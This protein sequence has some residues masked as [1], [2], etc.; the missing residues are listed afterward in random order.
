MRWTVHGERTIYDSEWMRLALVD[1]ELPSGPR[2]EHHVL[3]MPAEAAGVVI[4]VA[5]RG[6]LL[7]WRHRFITDTWGWEIP[8]GRVDS[9]ESVA[10]AA[11]RETVE[12]SGWQ[13]GELT[14]M[15]R[16][17]PANGSSD[18]TF[19]LFATT[20]AT[21]VGEPAEL[22]EAERVEWLT[23]DTVR[24]EIA[25]GN[26]RD[27]LSLTALLYRMTHVGNLSR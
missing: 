9:G 27:G 8:A 24:D 3:R 21:Y 5:G 18:A 25:A 23:W 20:A 6:V 4:D 12:E 7:L 22:D 11:H 1:I 14:L 17:F 10:E 16:Y 15:T 2:F 13:P 19:N 26:I